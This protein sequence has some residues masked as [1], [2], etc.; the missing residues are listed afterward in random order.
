MKLD[1]KTWLNK[2]FKLAGKWITVEIHYKVTN[3]NNAKLIF[4]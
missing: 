4:S 3:E 2:E 1:C